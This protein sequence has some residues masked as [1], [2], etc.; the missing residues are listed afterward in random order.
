M[1]AE[2]AAA[3][4]VLCMPSWVGF[5][6]KRE[7]QDEL[8]NGGLGSTE[9]EEIWVG[10]GFWFLVWCGSARIGEDPRGWKQKTGKFK[11]VESRD[12]NGQER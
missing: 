8:F 11:E 3:G 12:K 6:P 5:S 1:E 9:R 2:R 4:R 7:V 10:F